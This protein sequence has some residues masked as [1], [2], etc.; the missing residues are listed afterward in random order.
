MTLIEVTLV[1]ATLIGL[2][3]VTFV[4]TVSYKEGAN[5]ALCI[6]QMANVQKAMRAY[7]NFQEIEPGQTIPDLKKRV[8]D[9]AEFFQSPPTCPSGGTYTFAKKS[10]PNVGTL[11][12]RCSIPEHLPV[13]HYSW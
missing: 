1:V 4:G 5:R 11:F 9:D 10:V 6:H 13:D 12:M 8:I 3:S 7:C 2:I